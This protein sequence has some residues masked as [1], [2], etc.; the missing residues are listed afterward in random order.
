MLAVLGLTSIDDLFLDIPAAFRDPA[1]NLPKPLS[2]LGLQRELA[3]LASRN[4]SLG[5][6]PSFLGADSYHHF[7][8]AIVKALATRGEF[9]TAYT[10]YQAEA[11]QGTLQV[12]YE[13]QTL[14]CNLFAMDAANAG[15]YDGAT[16]LAEGVLMACRVTG[17]NQV[18]LA[19]TLSPTYQEVIRTYCQAQ[20]IVTRTVS[21]TSPE[22][23]GTT[24]CL[25]VQYPNCYGYVED[26][27]LLADAAH[28]SGAL[29]VASTDPIAMG[30]SQ[31][32]GHYGADIVT[33]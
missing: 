10:P 27:T 8:P 4:R 19:S 15:M 9:L 30:L 12:I 1:L 25:A 24:A 14:V 31:P 22:I 7:I 33:G 3:A 2:E 26:L 17:R 13:F 23:D 20:G 16:S 32:P 28:G 6:G 29:L 21:P 5:S 18:A 11:S